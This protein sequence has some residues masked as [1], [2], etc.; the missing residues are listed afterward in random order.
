M[1]NENNN[2]VHVTKKFPVSKDEL[3]SA[4]TEEE[5]LKQWWKPLNKQLSSVENDIREGG[6]VAYYFGENL[7]IVGEY[8]E[9]AQGD[10]LVYSWNWELPED[11]THKGEYLLTVKFGGS[12]NESTLDITQENFKHE[13]SI[14][15]HT[16]GWEEA[17]E[18]LKN[19]LSHATAS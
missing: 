3:Y 1:S 17:L 5:Q 14:K 12:E 10:K 2:S 4:W 9:V 6:R 8:K 7:Q 13:H 19:Y 15:P 18:D 16:T 11:S